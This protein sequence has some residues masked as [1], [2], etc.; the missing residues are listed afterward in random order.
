MR[1]LVTGASG[2]VGAAV[3]R[4]LLARSWETRCLVRVGSNRRNL[5][6]L[7]VETAV[8]DLTDIASLERALGGCQALFHVAADY[9]LGVRDADALYRNNVEG[10]RN[11]L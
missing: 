6:G 3:A 1:A 11:I 5:E 4:A 10:T 9:R 7:P 2:F 8:G